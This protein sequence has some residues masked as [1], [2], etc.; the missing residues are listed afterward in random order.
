MEVD[1][2]AVSPAVDVRELLVNNNPMVRIGV[3][4]LGD[5]ALGGSSLLDGEGRINWALMGHGSMAFRGEQRN[6]TVHRRAGGATAHGRAAAHACAANE[7]P[8]PPQAQAARDRGR[9]LFRESN[10]PGR[11]VHESPALLYTATAI[12]PRAH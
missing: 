8:L 12:G 4:S 3:M 7:T 1:G 5:L 6:V 2:S 11:P 9:D 10:W